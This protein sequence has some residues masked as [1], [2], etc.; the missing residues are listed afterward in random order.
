MAIL[1]YVDPGLGSLAWQ[2]IVSALVGLFFYLR[3][4]RKW[5]VN[6]CLKLF[7]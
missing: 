1:A 4:T 3:Q 7:H 6:V 5:I 2:T